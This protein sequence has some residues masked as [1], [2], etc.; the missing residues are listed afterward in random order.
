MDFILNA[1]NNSYNMRNF[2]IKISLLKFFGGKRDQKMCKSFTE[3]HNKANSQPNTNK[4]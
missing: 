3:C 1:I 2:T 4:L